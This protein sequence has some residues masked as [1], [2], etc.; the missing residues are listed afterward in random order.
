V[1]KDERVG[2]ELAGFRRWILERRLGML[3]TNQTNQDYWFGPLHLAAGVG[4]TLTVDDTSATSLYLTSDAVADALNNLYN[5]GKITVASAALP[6]PRP[7]GVPQLLHGDGSPDGSVFAA[8]GSA[9]LRRDNTGAANALYAKTTGVS[10]STGW[11]AFVGGILGRVTGSYDLNNSTTESSLVSG[12]AAS[13]SSGFK[14]PANTLGLTGAIRLT[15]L[16]D[17]LNN[18]GGN[19]TCTIKIKF[20]GTVFYGDLVSGI[21]ASANRYPVPLR[22]VLSN[23]DAADSNFLQGIAPAWGGGTPTAGS[24]AGI[25]GAIGDSRLVMSSVEA[26]DTTVDQ[27]LD[28]TATHGAANSNLSIRRLAAFAEAL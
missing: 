23:L 14:I 1:L 7:T 28:V 26:I 12:A 6:F 10:F 22:V 20:G 17:Y 13:S 15:V 21:A 27:Y 11:E 18:T 5:T 16:A 25:I 9:F 24:V 19:Q 3:V 8:Q 2:G 4:E